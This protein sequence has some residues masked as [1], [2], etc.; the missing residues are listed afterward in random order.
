[1]MHSWRLLSVLFVMLPYVLWG[2]NTLGIPLVFN[3]SKAVF[4]GGSRTWDIK[5]DSRGI[6]YFANNDGLITFNGHY[7]STYP[8]PNTTILRSLEIDENDRI[9]VG[10]QGEFGYFEGS[11]RTTLHYTSLNDLV[12]QN[13]RNF[14]D[15][16]NTATFGQSVFFRA[17]DRI[18]QLTDGRIAV[19]TPAAEW[20]FLGR[21]GK[22]LF[23]QDKNRGLLEFRNN[24]WTSLENGNLMEGINIAS[25]FSLGSD[26]IFVATITNKTFLLLGNTLQRMDTAPWQD[27]YTPSFAKISDSTYVAATAT[28]GCIIRNLDGSAMQH[29][30]NAEGLQNNNVSKVFIDKDQNIW[31]G[32]D[33][34]IAVISYNSAVK[35]FRPNLENDVTG[36]STRI[37]KNNLYV[38]SSNGV[39]VAPLTPDV[40]DHSLSRS[41]FSLVSVSDRGEAWRL[42]EVNGQ[43]LL[44]HNKGVFAITDSIASPIST[45]TGSWMFLPLSSPPA[46][47]VLVGTYRGIDLLRYANGL[48]ER[49]GT[50]AGQADSYRFL[51]RDEQGT[52]WASHPYRGIYRLTLSPDSTEYTVRLYTNKDGLPSAFQNFVFNIRN[53][54]VFATEAGVYEFDRATDRFIPSE[55]FGQFTGIPI[56]YLQDDAEGNVWFCS[57]KRI[58]VAKFASGKIAAGITY[59]PEIEGLNTSGFENIYPYD[60]NNVY[61]GSET[62]II[63]INYEKYQA[64]TP[65]PSVL[66]SR[67]NTTNGKDS[68][69]FGGYFPKNGTG[70]FIQDKKQI[71][72]LHA[73][74]DAFHFEYGSP[75][76]G[77]QHQLTYSYW[78]EGYDTGWSAWSAHTEK[79]YTNL[80]S[81]TYT[82][83]VK[84]RNN[85]NDESETAVFSFV[86][87]PPWYQTRWAVLGYV[88]AALIGIYLL[89]RWQQRMW[90]R[91]RNKYEEQLAQLRYIH[92]LEIEKN[93]KEIVK[94]QN[95]KLEN[96]VWVKTKELANTSMQLMENTDALSKVKIELKK[97]HLSPEDESDLKRITSLLKDIEKNSA[98]WDQFASHFDELNDG[99]L[100]RLKAQHPHLSRND[101]KVCA[102]LRLNFSSKQI[103]QLQ[104]ISVR[105][106]EIHRY[107][108]RKK[109]GLQTEVSLNEYLT[110]V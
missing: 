71:P 55:S 88:I 27:L 97:L 99:F 4:Q 26:S 69:I 6:L 60:K 102:Y 38:S 86:I 14:A 53:R 18:F 25:V 20:L 50:L 42:E 59:F 49:A 92:Q 23:A 66:L 7:W 33:N 9:Y 79:D 48:F 81:G 75:S 51:E 87:C 40:A 21:A 36:F 110:S 106:V 45:G 46:R 29:I 95:E 19:H 109:L 22:R 3:Y 47:D 98:N 34:A 16:W 90:R 37:F 89:I 30:A 41:T 2:Q 80:P 12:P 15:V 44:A 52:I 70:S 73:S 28:A 10:G 101:L 74:F 1:M 58:G 78:L 91:Q 84:A 13:H 96:E 105:G 68:T 65:R 57:G 56:K 104:N 43:L 108:L 31:A 39:Y 100:N 8:L 85:L 77:I 5:Q 72:R 54:I 32:I 103:A 61:I 63:H 107:R 94:L 62:G 67:V 64:N 83:K 35:Y 76:Y 82:F 17:T 24:Q 93:E 11:P